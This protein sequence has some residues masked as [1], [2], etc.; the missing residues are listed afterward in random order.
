VREGALRKVLEA[1]AEDL[2]VR[3]E[4][5][6]SECFINATFIVPKKGTPSGKDQA[7]QKYEAHVGGRPLWSSS[8]RP[9]GVCF[10]A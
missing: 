3:G 6:L 9:R 7:G 2:L 8:R 4:L 5:D 10:A 1:L